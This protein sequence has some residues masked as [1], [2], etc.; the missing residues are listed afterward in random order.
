MWITAP[1][2]DLLEDRC[3]GTFKACSLILLMI[4]IYSPRNIR[5]LVQHLF[6]ALSLIQSWLA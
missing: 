3:L 5:E 6:V 1:V 2:L 4:A